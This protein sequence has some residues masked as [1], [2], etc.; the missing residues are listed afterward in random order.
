MRPSYMATYLLM[1]L[2]RTIP[3]SA[4]TPLDVQRRLEMPALP[5]LGSAFEGGTY[6]YIVV[7][8]GT[9][10]MTIAARL[11]EDPNI[12]VAV[13]EAGV[14]Y[15]LLPTNKPL[16]DTPGADTIGCGSKQYDAIND[17]V[18]WRF[19][20]TPQAGANNRTVRYARGKTIGGSSARNFMIYQRPSKGSL[21]QWAELT[22]DHQWTFENRFADYQKSVSFTAPK[23]DLR[24]ELPSAQ[25]DDR[26]YTQA[27]GPVQLSYPNM[28]QPFSKYMQL[29]LNEKGIPTCRDFNGGTLSGVQ[30]ATTTIDPETGHRSTSRAFF[31]AARSRSNLVV[32]TTAM[33]KEILFDES[34]PPQAQGI[35]FL[36]TLTGLSDKLIAKKEVIVSAGAFQS[37]QLLMVSGIGPKEQLVAHSIPIRVESPNVG[38]GMQDHIFFGPTYPVHTIETLTRIAA[39]PDHLTAQFLNFTLRQQGPLTNNV[40]DMISFET[41]DDSK[42]KRLNSP[43]LS[44]YPSDWPHVEYLSAAGVVGDFANLLTTNALAGAATGKE[45]VTILAA[46]VAPQSRGTVKLASNDAS[47]PPLIDPGW[48]TDPVDQRI[49]VEAFKRTREF[50]SAQAMQPILDGPEYLP[51]PSVNSDDEILDWIRNNLMTVWHAACTCSMRTREQG[52]VLDSHFKVYGAKNLRV[53][54]ASAFPS[55]PPGHPQSTV[56]MIAERAA[57][58]IKQE[59]S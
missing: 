59:Y 36:Y 2:M 20:T 25:Y 21:D 34:T 42:L 4:N 32:Y 47:V 12:R 30:Y 31:S 57:A 26:F 50:F 56:Y 48:L 54:D 9:A 53:V 29:S 22:G 40:A 19:D 45:F 39:H 24:Q 16:V 8:A 33:A 55:L 10:G 43:S 38:R 14:D 27:N 5:V 51:G 17:A 46:L 3:L 35:E 23:H 58:L 15:A 18:D 11:S 7:G 6:D 52:G 41:F 28:A 49:A 37:P 44:A 13:V 1:C